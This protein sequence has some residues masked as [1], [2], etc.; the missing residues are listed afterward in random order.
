[1]NH[2]TELKL[3]YRRKALPIRLT[4]ISTYV[5]YLMVITSFATV[6]YYIIFQFMT[7]R[8]KAKKT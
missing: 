8:E 3:Y 6:V 4:F 5:Y 7:K 1:M 2:I